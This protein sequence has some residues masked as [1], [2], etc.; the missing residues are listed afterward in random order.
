MRNCAIRGHF[1]DG[2][3]S[4]VSYLPCSKAAIALLSRSCSVFAGSM[5]GAEEV[6]SFEMVGAA[7]L[8]LCSLR[9]WL[10][11]LGCCLA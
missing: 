8:L 3:Q 4:P 2:L 7:V 10:S 9:G 1:V 5:D 6:N 11:S